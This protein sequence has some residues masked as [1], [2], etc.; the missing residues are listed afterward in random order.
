[1]HCVNPSSRSRPDAHL[2]RQ[3]FL[4]L[5][6]AARRDAFHS[7]CSEAGS[8]VG[9][10]SPPSSRRMQASSYGR[11]PRNVCMK[12]EMHEI[13]FAL[14]V[15]VYF[16]FL[17]ALAV[18]CFI[19]MR[20]GDWRAHLGLIRA[21]SASRDA[22]AVLTVG[23]SAKLKFSSTRFAVFV[24]AIKCLPVRSIRAKHFFFPVCPMRVCSHLDTISLSGKRPKI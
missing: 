8:K 18:P 2:S 6:Q 12:P 9:W 3:C 24:A 21:A 20:C 23:S 10:F 19:S 1:M 14:H 17:G 5:R 7:L 15:S 22:C 16:F 4:Q 13:G 11:T